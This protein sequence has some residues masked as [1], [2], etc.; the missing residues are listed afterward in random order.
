MTKSI[1]TQ[2]SPRVGNWRQPLYLML[3]IL[4]NLGLWT[5]ALVVLKLTPTAYSSKFAITLP[6]SASSTNV[7]LPNIG[8]ASYENYS[9][10]N[11]STQDPRENYKL[12]ASSEAVLNRAAAMVDLSPEEFGEPRIKIVTNT[13]IMEFS[14]NGDTASQAQAKAQALYAALQQR[15]NHLRLQ[16]IKQRD[17]GF[18]FGLSAAQTKL[19]IA[20]KRLSDYKASSGLNSNDQIKSFS[21]NIEQLRRQRAEIEAQQQQASSRFKQLSASL[22][23]SGEQANAAFVLKSDRLFQQLLSDY[24][25][26]SS[27]LT[28][29]S[30]RYLSTHPLVN[31]EQAKQQAI[32]RAL[33]TRGQLLVG[34][35]TTLTRLQQLNLSNANSNSAQ[36]QLLQQVVAVQADRSGYN[37]QARELERQIASLEAR[38]K[39]LAQHE[40]TLDALKRDLQ[41]AEAVFSSTLA[42]LDIGRANASG[43]YPLLQLLAEPTLPKSSTHLKLLLVLLGTVLTSV[44]F[45]VGIVLLWRRQQQFERFDYEG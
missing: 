14:L 43:S 3:V 41:I 22:N 20:Q 42:R 6:S 36:E 13:S 26:S 34:E 28:A 44:F 21:D 18:Q 7:N 38:L 10:Y 4:V 30:T 27:R 31:S 23:T 24:S 9:P 16:E 39:V 12:I 19:E 1:E 37:A 35:K 2:Y 5:A 15:L 29:L 17:A 11:A 32:A 33:L 40:T 8:A 25:D 45:T